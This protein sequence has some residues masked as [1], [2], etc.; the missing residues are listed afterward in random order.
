[1]KLGKAREQ[2]KREPLTLVIQFQLHVSKWKQSLSLQ[3]SFTVQEVP[4]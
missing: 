2:H 3:R 1:M 4:G